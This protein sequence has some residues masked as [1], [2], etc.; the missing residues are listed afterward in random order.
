MTQY[1]RDGNIYLVRV[2]NIQF[3]KPKEKGDF[4]MTKPS[5]A[6]KL[7]DENGYYKFENQLRENFKEFISLDQPMFLIKADDSIWEH[8]LLNIE[9]S[10]RQHYNCNCCKS[11]IRKYGRLVTLDDDANVI[12]VLWKDREDTPSY[13]KA[14][15]SNLRD[16]VERQPIVAPFYSDEL[17]LGNMETNGWGHLSLKLEQNS[18]F[19]NKS[20]LKTANQIMADKKQDAIILKRALN[21]YSKETINTALNVLK[22]DSVYRGDRF[23][24]IAEW[25][26]NVKDAYEANTSEYT[27]ENIIWFSV[28]TA[29]EGY[30]HI[31]SSMIGTLLDDIKAGF[32]FDRVAERFA[33]KMNPA[34]YQRSQSDPTESAVAQAE[35]VIMALGVADSLERRYA[36]IDEIPEFVWKSRQPKVEK[37]ASGGIFGNIKTK[38]KP[39]KQVDDSLP[40]VTMTWDKFSR[41]VLPNASKIEARIDNTNRLSALVTA[42]NPESENILQWS[43]PFSWYYHGGVDGEIKR[44]VEEAGGRY[45][46]ND[47]RCS[48]L[49]NNYTDLDLHC[50]TPTG[51]H[52]FYG[53]ERSTGGYLDIDKNVSPETLTPIE[54]IRWKTGDA[55]DG[56]YKFYV[57]CFSDRSGYGNSN[58]Y[59]VELEIEG[60]IYTYEGETTREEVVFEFEYIKGQEPVFVG[61]QPSSSSSWNIDN[62]SFAK[63]SGI[64]KSPNLWGDNP[65]ERVGDHTFFLLDGC[66]DESEGKGRGFF[67]EFLK[68]DL[69]EV[70]KTL[71]AYTAQTPIQG[72]EDASACGL[73]FSKESDW[74]LVLRVTDSGLSRL[75]KI[76]RL[77]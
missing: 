59:K 49:W 9:E 65:L 43:N 5:E 66:K 52:I 16:F 58:Q 35:R 7:E 10:G 62:G 28:A 56:M 36:T 17:D 31:R 22:S 30:C 39:V 1:I 13:F 68:S 24:G 42:V 54:N 76:D 33:E 72:S 38:E 12:S 69:K 61:T 57:N 75:I 53:N 41:T 51:S 55:R 40:T 20:R 15:V 19:K 50:I 63:I 71:E 44:R 64:T 32:T 48:L 18:K 70:R 21:E 29:N 60:K 73:G 26:K 77:D 2:A 4:K 14:A 45:E 34:N 46:N 74:N 23:V 11:F 47:I 6:Y 27:K 3:N 8:Y 37:K 67:N 25:F